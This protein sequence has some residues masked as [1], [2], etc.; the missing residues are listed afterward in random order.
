[1]HRAGKPF[2]VPYILRRERVRRK[3]RRVGK[4]GAAAVVAARDGR[5]E[6]QVVCGMPAQDEP[7]QERVVRF[8]QVDVE[9]EYAARA[10][11][12]LS[13]VARANSDVES[14]RERVGRLAEPGAR[15]RAVVERAAAK[16]ID[17]LILLR[18]EV[19]EAGESLQTS[20]QSLELQCRL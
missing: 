19:V 4:S 11:P 13:L 7:W 15:A 14:L 5:A 17:K 12:A 10:A 20:S 6:R 16:E 1:Q 9:D 8:I 2:V 18:T 3:R